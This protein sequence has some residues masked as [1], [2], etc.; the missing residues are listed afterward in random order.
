[1]DGYYKFKQKFGRFAVE[2]L[3][4]YVT[5]IFAI[6]YLLIVTGFGT[7][8]M[9]YLAFYPKQVLH[10]QIWRILTAIFVPPTFTSNLLLGALSIF[11]YYNFASVV[12]RS[13]GEFEY[14]LYFF[15]SILIGELG[16][17]IYYLITGENIF[18]YTTYSTFSVFMAF[19][20]LYSE[21]RVLLF[22]IIPIKVKYVAWVELAI[23]LFNMITAIVQKDLYSVISIIAALIPVGIFYLTVQKNRSGE[24]LI[25]RIQFRAK[26]R[27]RQKEWKSYWK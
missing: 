2:N 24:N 6:G 11:I 5:V 12:E 26:Q 25:S 3:S 14:N 17:L 10:G 21:A 19:A 15:G 16:T 22:F 4:L 13:M 27:E 1:M 18:F 20:I 7:N 8:I 9:Q 23:Y